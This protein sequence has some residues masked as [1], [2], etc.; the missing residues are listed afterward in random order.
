MSIRKSEQKA[1]PAAPLIR[2]K[3]IGIASLALALFYGVVVFGFGYGQHVPDIIFKTSDAQ[4][5][6]SVGEWLFGGRQTASTLIRPFLYP[7]VMKTIYSV[8]GAY[9]VWL[10]QFLLWMLAGICVYLAVRKWTSS[11]LLASAGLVLFASN[12]SLILLTMHAL[13]E[14][15]CTALL[16]VGAWIVV[17]KDRIEATRF[18]TALMLL[19]SLLSVIKPVYFPLLVSMLAYT[20]YLVLRRNLTVVSRRRAA[21]VL[22]LI[23][24]P[25][26]VQTGIMKIRHDVFGIS[27]IGSIT[28]KKYF[29][30]ACYAE[31]NKV[32]L[33]QA[34]GQI[35]H[36]STFQMIPIVLQDGVSAVKIWTELM[37]LNLKAG[38]AVT[39]YPVV[40][41][42]LYYFIKQVNKLT[43]LL[44]LGMVLPLS[45]CFFL[46]YRLRKNGELG[47]FVILLCPIVWVIGTSGLTF[48]Q[49]DRIVL[50]VL[51]VW[52]VLYL[53]TFRFCELHLTK[54]FTLKR[55]HPEP[56]R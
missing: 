38:S 23:L 15:I 43:Y 56:V 55:M 16:A 11:V 26:L 46:L 54:K 45:F 49:G 51:P 32:S 35:E 17:N 8:F 2:W 29:V 3:E 9:G 53:F 48:W 24:S 42:R 52:I 27:K 5:Y 37:K 36:L 47:K 40:H 39:K 44:H 6:K 18:W 33:K 28:A 30:A 41:L 7:L 14:V 12:I 22:L 20:G 31:A 21:F 50:P 10:W 4:T 13:A 25:V 19:C 34:R 1:S